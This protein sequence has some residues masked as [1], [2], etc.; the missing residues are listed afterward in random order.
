MNLSKA[1]I[2]KTKK[3]ISVKELSRYLDESQQTATSI[4]KSI[5]EIKQPLSLLSENKRGFYFRVDQKLIFI[6]I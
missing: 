2:L 5:S 1:E 3:N 4:T 6:S